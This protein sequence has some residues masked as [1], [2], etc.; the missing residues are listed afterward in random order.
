MV[1]RSDG[2]WDRVDDP[3]HIYQRPVPNALIWV[4]PVK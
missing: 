4:K 3:D 1:R 2:D